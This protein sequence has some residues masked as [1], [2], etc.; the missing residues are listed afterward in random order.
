M[1][2]LNVTIFLTRDKTALTESMDNV[3][4]K[5]TE[6]TVSA[7][8]VICVIATITIVGT[9]TGIIVIAQINATKREECKQLTWAPPAMAAIKNP[10]QER[11][12]LQYSF[13]VNHL[14]TI[15]DENQKTN[16]LKLFPGSILQDEP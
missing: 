10:A 7:F 8:T 9:I 1:F 4:K 2:T 13:A 6:F 11:S 16:E 12:N 5:L 14:T 15:D 3:W